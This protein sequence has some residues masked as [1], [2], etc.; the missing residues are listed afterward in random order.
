MDIRQNTKEILAPQWEKN[1]Q[2]CQEAGTY[3]PITQKRR[4][5]INPLE[6]SRNDPDNL[7]VVDKDILKSMTVF[8]MFKILEGRIEYVK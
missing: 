2:A 8:H 5:K 3:N 7:E 6:T 4:R 1:H